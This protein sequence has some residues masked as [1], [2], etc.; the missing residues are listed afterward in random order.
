MHLFQY[1]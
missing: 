1:M